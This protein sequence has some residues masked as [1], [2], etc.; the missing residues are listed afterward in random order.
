MGLPL[1][2]AHL[3]AAIAGLVLAGMTATRPER[4]T[5]IVVVVAVVA[6]AVNA[7]VVLAELV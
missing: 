6:A 2:V 4:D 7:G 1:I 5:W 3:I